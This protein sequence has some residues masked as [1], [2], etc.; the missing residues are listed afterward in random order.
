MP[1]LNF[2]ILS[3][4]VDELSTQE[5]LLISTTS[6][7]VHGII[8]H[9]VLSSVT[10][11]TSKAISKFPHFILVDPSSR[12]PLLRSLDVTIPFHIDGLDSILDIFTMFDIEDECEGFAPIRAFASFLTHLFSQ[13]HNLRMLKLNLAGYFFVKYPQLQ[14]AFINMDCLVELSLHDVT[15]PMLHVIKDMRSQLRFLMLLYPCPNQTVGQFPSYFANMIPQQRLERLIFCVESEMSATFPHGMETQWPTV[16]SL[17]VEGDSPMTPFVS[18]FPSVRSLQVNLSNS[19][20]RDKSP[21]WTSLDYLA[22]GDAD[23]QTWYICCPVKWLELHTV[24]TATD[25]YEDTI[26]VIQRTSPMI[27]SLHMLSNLRSMKF[28][29]TLGRAAKHVKLLEVSVED[30]WQ[31]RK[32]MQSWMV[33]MSKSQTKWRSRM[34]M[35]SPI[36]ERGTIHGE[37]ASVVPFHPFYGM[38]RNLRRRE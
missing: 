6:K 27:L 5:A 1:L 28:W 32:Y 17:T 38:H 3:L 34:I 25:G 14:E 21:H 37:V 31:G 11:N 33:S 36:G 12:I 7:A 22:G 19:L 30:G 24:L 29:K 26:D 9:H 20:I 35:I 18:A 10:I 15:G 4:I 16:H 8:L 13:S 2:D 23:F